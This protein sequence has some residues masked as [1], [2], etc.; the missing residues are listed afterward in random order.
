[1]EHFQ[2]AAGKQLGSQML[3]EPESVSLSPAK[4]LQLK[5]RIIFLHTPTM[6]ISRIFIFLVYLL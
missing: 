3:L 4:R 2:W 1:M 5:E 6:N